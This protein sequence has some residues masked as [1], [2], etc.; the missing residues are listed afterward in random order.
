MNN[1]F[2]T[3]ANPGQSEILVGALY[4]SLLSAF[5]HIAEVEGAPAAVAFKDRLLDRIG[6]GDISMSLLDDAATF[7]LA[8]SMIKDIVVEG[9]KV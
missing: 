4:V 2:G 5:R 6:S 8:T 3:S 7:D 9:E 1:K